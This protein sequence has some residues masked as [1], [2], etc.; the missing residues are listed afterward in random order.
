MIKFQPTA[1]I[2]RF[3]NN[4]KDVISSL[5]PI[6]VKGKNNSISI[7]SKL[8]NSHV[9]CY[10][11][12]NSITIGDKCILENT[13]FYIHG[14]NNKLFIDDNVKIHGGVIQVL[15]ENASV[16]I[17][18][19]TTIMSAHLVAENETSITIGEDC[20]LAHNV[21]IRTSDSHPIY[22][23]H[24]KQ[25][26][27]PDQSIFLEEHVWIAENALILKGVTIGKNSVVGSRSIVTRNVE[28]N[29]VVAGVPAKVV[30][31]NA[32]WKRRVTDKIDF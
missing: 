11:F 15:G 6:Y 7:L 29:K 25:R 30:K 18:R 31:E 2:H 21:E 20:M 27:N 5:I 3:F 23:I 16:S 8:Y 19:R 1:T 14:N 17:A 28:S 13:T 24:S 4:I 32:I 12:N 9:N 26:T 22:N 10:G